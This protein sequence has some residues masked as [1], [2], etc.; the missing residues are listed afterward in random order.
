[1]RDLASAEAQWLELQEELETII[2]ATQADTEEG[3]A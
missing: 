1:M 2:A 3:A